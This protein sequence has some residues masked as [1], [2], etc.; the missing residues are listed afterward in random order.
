MITREGW[1]DRLCRIQSAIHACQDEIGALMRVGAGLDIGSGYSGQATFHEP[2]HMLR[3]TD[4]V[5]EKYGTDTKQ[6]E[7][8]KRLSYLMKLYE[9]ARNGYENA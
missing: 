2:K 8:E 4:R 9:V 3:V 7:A 5:R 1:L 6:A